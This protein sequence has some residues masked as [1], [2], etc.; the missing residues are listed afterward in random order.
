MVL[1]SMNLTHV[2]AFFHADSTRL[3]PAS[4]GAAEV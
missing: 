2:S 3:P 1:T 4:N